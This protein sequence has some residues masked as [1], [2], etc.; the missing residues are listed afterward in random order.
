MARV[1]A[2]RDRS[3]AID[4]HGVRHCRSGGAW[5]NFRV[6]G[7]A[8]LRAVLADRRDPRHL[9]GLSQQHGLCPL[10]GSADVVG[11]GD[12]RVA[13]SGLRSRVSSLP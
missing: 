6:E 9:P 5:P 13:Q 10:L 11:R 4:D 8:D 12:A 1:G 3:P 7:A 2:G